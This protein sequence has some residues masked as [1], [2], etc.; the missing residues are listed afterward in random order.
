MMRSVWAI[1][2]LCLVAVLVPQVAVGQ[3]VQEYR[4]I[5]YATVDGKDLGMDIYVPSQVES[6]PLVVFVHGGRWQNGSKDGVTPMLHLLDAGYAVAS[7]DFR[8]STEARFPAMVHDIKGGLRFLRAH[9]GDYGYGADRIAISGTS[10][11]GHLA[12]LVGVTNGHPAL[13]G[14]VG[15]NVGVASDVQAIVSYYGASDLT[16]ILSQSTPYGHGVREPALKLLLGGLPSDVSELTRLASPVEHV[17]PADP[18]LL[19]MHGDRDPQMPINQS[20]QL[21]GAYEALGLDVYFDVVHGA[22]HGG[23]AFFDS[24]HWAGLIAF[25]N[26]TIAD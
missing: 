15:G 25:L 4:D 16:T 18:P 26:R 19:L 2:I 5:V 13:E 22:A 8:Q 11:G 14:T 1:G 7:L 12:A 9:A 24:D 20:H 3:G 6:A 21:E 10:S 17:D 23:D